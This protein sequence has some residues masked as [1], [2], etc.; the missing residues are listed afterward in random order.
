M[1]GALSRVRC[2]GH[3][4]RGRSRGAGGRGRRAVGAG[5]GPVPIGDVDARDRASPVPTGVAE[6]DRVLERRPRA[7]LGHAARRRA[8]HGQEHAAPAGARRAW[9][10]AARACLLVTR[11]GVVRS[12]CACAAERVGALD[13]GAAGRGRDVAARTSS[14]TSTRSRPRCSRSTRSR[15]SSIPTCPAR[16]A[17]S[18]RCATARYRLVQQAKERGAGHGARRPRHQGGHARRAARCSS[19]SSTPCSRSTATAVTRCALLH[20]LKH[21]FGSTQELG[22]FEMTERGLVDV[23]D[24][25]ARFLVDRRPGVP[26]SAVAAGAR[27]RAA[28]AGRGAGAGRARPTRRCRAGRPPASMA[29]GRLAMLLAVLEQHAGVKSTECRRLRERRR[30]P[31]GHRAGRRPRARA[32]GRGAHARAR[33]SPR[34]TVVVGEIG[35]GGEVRVGRRSSSAGSPK[36]R[37][38]GSRAVVAEGPHGRAAAAGR[39][40]SSR[41][42][43]VRAR[44]RRS[45]RSRRADP[46][47]AG[48]PA[49]PEAFG[50]ATG[51]RRG[52]AHRARPTAIGSHDG[53]PAPRR[54]RA[55]QL[56]E[57]LDRILQARMGALIVVGDGP[58]VL[59]VCSGGFLLDAE[60]TPQRLSELAKM[61]GAIILAADSSRVARANVHLVPDPNIP[62][63]GDR[64]PPPHRRAGRAPDRRP[65]DHRVGG[66]VGGR[67]PPPRREAHARADPPGA[68]PRRPGAADPRAATRR[69]STR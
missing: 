27:G 25:S 57:G 6:L 66:H 24:A 69:A 64:H 29:V 1:A 10:A 3:A 54:R 18:R 36:R 38:S 11:R 42:T 40:R 39:R 63:V 19:T 58:D 4:G 20:A 50:A 34:D 62:T 67:H 14:R 28:D 33:R 41:S 46:A 65:G 30:W 55:R 2:V 35:L 45:A 60:F 53:R 12:R 21:R 23:P 13:A 32:R 49:D 22:L 16:P 44:G 51:S 52:R 43:G 56:R 17:R 26:G 7:R 59:S 37:G 48:L 5:D 8:G 15:P 31:A 47:D 9:P 68:G 61:D